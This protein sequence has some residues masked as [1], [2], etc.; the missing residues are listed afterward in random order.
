MT[1][2]A[3]VPTLED[4]TPPKVARL[5][6]LR[7]LVLDV[8]FR[9]IA[10][11]GWQRAVTLVLGGSAEAVVDTD[12][13]VTSPSVAIVVPSVIRLTGRALV[14]G[15]RR[16][17]LA[18]KRTVHERDKWT[19]A[20]CGLRARTSLERDDMTVDHIVPRSRGGSNNDFGNLVTAC[21]PCNGR[22]ADRTPEE[23]GMRLRLT[24]RP[25]TWAEQTRWALTGGPGKPVPEAWVPFLG[26]L[27]A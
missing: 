26:S 14:V 15:R 21:R 6:D 27:A 16:G 1:A 25:P 20:Y 13:I 3:A 7:V 4:T 12:R 2:P 22:K 5:G 18:R 19:C 24:P 17:M 11:I 10:A 23:A 8:T 9:P